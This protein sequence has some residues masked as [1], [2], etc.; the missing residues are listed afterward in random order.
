MNKTHSVRKHLIDRPPCA[1]EAGHLLVS[2]ITA[3]LR[4]FPVHY[5]I[6]R[7]PNKESSEKQ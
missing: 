1:P 5:G 6:E 3:A 7:A 2:L 4:D